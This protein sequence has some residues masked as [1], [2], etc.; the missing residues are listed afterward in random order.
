MARSRGSQTPTKKFLARQEREQRQQRM[1]LAGT[2]VILAVVIGLILYGVLL[3]NVIRPRQ[4]VATVNGENIIARDFVERTRFERNNLVQQAL[5]TAQ[6]LQFLGSEQSDFALNIINN[7][8]QIQFQLEPQTFGREVLNAMIDD[9]LVRKDAEERGITVSDEE[10]QREIQRQFG[11]FP[12]GPQPTPTEFPT[13]IPTSTLSPEQLALV[14]PVST[15][16]D[17]PTA[18]PDPSLTPTEEP[19][20]TP[21]SA[22][23]LTPT[24]ITEE[25]FNQTYTETIEMFKSEVNVSETTIRQIILA[26]LYRQKLMEIFAK[27]IALTEE[28]VWARH[29]LVA[30]E[31]TALQVLEQ[32]RDGGD[33]NQ[34]AA[35][36][37]TD[38]SNKDQGGNL[39]WFPRNYMVPEFEQVAFALEVG[40]VSDPVQSQFG[41]HII[42]VLGHEERSRSE[43]QYEQALQEAFQTW[44]SAERLE[45][46]IEI[47]EVWTQVVPEDPDIPAELDALIQQFQN[48]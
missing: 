25:S 20:P 45:A 23:T 37:S 12:D 43:F 15:A 17:L 18:T 2:V 26:Q 7:I 28:Q 44:L 14:T 8:Q 5:S 47:F 13:S 32:Y 19:S 48:Q 1:I 27:D 35:E 41:W 9:V 38:T 40:E 16:T 4:V 33:W 39:G 11:Y 24:P 6:T 21:T 3:N 36:F 22:P 46:N 31:A 42:Q 34:L 30:D 29:I 10:V